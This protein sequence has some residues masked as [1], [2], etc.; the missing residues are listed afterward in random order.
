MKKLI[1]LFA[2]LLCGTAQIFAQTYDDFLTE[3]RKLEAK[4]KEYGNVL[5][6]KNNYP[7]S[8]KDSLY[9]YLKEVREKKL[10]L[11]RNAI[12]ANPDDARFVD[13]L[14][15]YVFNFLSIDELRKELD[16]FT[17][18]ARENPTWGKM[19]SY[20]TYKPLNAVGQKAYDFTVKGHD[21]REIRLSEE[22]KHHKLLLVDF[23]AS[24]CGACR[25][26][27]PGLKKLY[28][29]YKGKG[30]GVL[31]VSLDDKA[32]N[33][34]KAFEKENLPWTDGSNLLG[35]NDPVT[36]RYAIRGIPHWILVGPDCTIVGT[37]IHGVA[38]LRKFLDEYF[39]K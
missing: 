23:W 25:A 8:Y 19:D 7:Q 15:F 6:K 21:G 10:S 34:E 3:M 31:S 5:F 18:K 39:D 16:L 20:I 27:M 24:W 35:W 13:V 9:P 29:A 1:V 32:G 14:N 28:E 36:E 37:D 30:F 38:A 4:E 2:L 33:W 22:A 17:P 11:A 26:S 12:H